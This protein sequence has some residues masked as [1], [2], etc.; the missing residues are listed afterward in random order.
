MGE[1]MGRIGKS[2]EREHKFRSGRTA[3]VRQV[4]SA[5]S[6]FTNQ[7]LAPYMTEFAT[8]GLVDPAVAVAICREVVRLSLVDPRLADEGEDVGEGV[9]SLDDL[10]QDEIDELVEMWQA[11]IEGAATFRD[12]PVGGGGGDGGG[13]VDD[14]A[15][16]V[17]RPR[18]R[19]R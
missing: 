16:P 7:V 13:G 12:E 4:H 9:V 18:A 19:K 6:V 14:D 8:G 10:Y 5:V 3:V 1:P 11:N 15:K 17:A 2:P